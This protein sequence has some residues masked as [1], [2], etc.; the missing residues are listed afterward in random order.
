MLVH[1]KL[2]QRAHPSKLKANGFKGSNILSPSEKA[3]QWRD[4]STRDNDGLFQTVVLQQLLGVSYENV[5]GSRRKQQCKPCSWYNEDEQ[6]IPCVVCE[7]FLPL[8]Q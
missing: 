7:M 3:E 5:M 2:L 4:Q 6:R 1:E 8:K